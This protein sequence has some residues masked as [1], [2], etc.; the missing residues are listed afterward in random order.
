MLQSGRSV[1]RSVGSSPPMRLI[2]RL[3]TA[4][5][6]LR[7]G[8]TARRALSTQHAAPVPRKF[9]KILIANRG[10]IALRVIRSAHQLGIETVAVYSDA[11]ANAQHVK[12]ATEAYRLGPA[13][14]SES[15]LNY[16]KILDVCKI[17]GAE[18]VHPG[19]GFLSENAE[20]CRACADANIEF[21][22]PPV[23]A[24]EAMGSKSASKD[25]MI[26]AG[27]PVTPGYHGEV[28]TFERLRDEARKIGYPVLIKAVLG[29]GGK[30]MRIVNDE[31]EF[32][33]A[34]E[35]C[36]REGKASFGDARVL[37]EKY[38]RKPRHVELQVFGDKFGN[39]IHLFERDCSV[40]RRHQKVLEEAP[41]PHMSE[42][43]RKKMG[44]AA[45]AAAKAVGY[46]GAGT[47]EFLLDEDES[48][49]FMEMNTRLQVEHPVTELITKQ[50]LVAMQLNVAAGQPLPIRQ[51]DLKI[52]GHAIEARIYAE[53]PYNNFLPGSG[54]L[55]HL[56]LPKATDHVRVDTGVIE[57]DE[58]SIFYDPMIAKLIVHGK[59]RDDALDKMVAALHD[60]QIVGLPTNIEFVARTAAHPEFRKGGVDTS[61]LNKHGDDVLKPLD[62][63]PTHA[64]AL[65]AVS[66][67]LLEQLKS[68]PL[69]DFNY[70]LHSPW[71]ED[72]LK[73]YRSL[74]THE[75][76]FQLQH[77]GVDVAVS[78]KSHEH[79][80]Y[81][82]SLDDKETV[83]A[84]GSLEADGD[85]AIRVG[86]RLYRG[87]AV[88]EKEDLHVF[89][90]DGTQRYEYKFHVP[91]P[92]L[93]STDGAG[94][95]GVSQIVTPMPG[96]II[97]VLV[98]SGDA[99]KEDQPLLIMEAMKMEH[100]IRATK[101]GKVEEVF[102]EEN[103]FV[104]D[105]HVLIALD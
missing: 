14:A 36:Q 19:Y 4:S 52:H 12:H 29:G 62:P 92:S 48:F 46:V 5:A 2:P 33:D 77:E 1:H 69:A 18:A 37:I 61:F 81:E 99:I 10:E 63:F 76:K 72:S 54:T 43:L 38:L 74:A 16:A 26:T 96:K 68:R 15:Y 78:V 23:K 56:R 71:S 73:H 39:V 83:V 87:T 94:G 98:K 27:V 60:Y 6:L 59:D 75:R 17:S 100:V 101:D 51:E 31:S 67:L 55:K 11:D 79:G 103:D 35:A 85:F 9:K 66:L 13:P 47:V 49:Y 65:G 53:N 7:H 95:V 57:G 58:V 82:V 50:D 28:Q 84:T 88:V 80:T 44:D 22:G 42:A 97:K 20:F 40:Q 8:M 90:N 104:T 70:E 32:K 3:S 64:K 89:C 41:A 30:G 91:L 93:S 21:I 24:I 45:V 86:E 25:I 105:G 34:L 102:C